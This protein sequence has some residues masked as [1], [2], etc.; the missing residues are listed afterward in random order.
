MLL[1]VAE[2]LL[3]F[4]EFFPD[5]VQKS[6][7]ARMQFRPWRLITAQLQPPFRGG[8]TV[9]GRFREPTHTSSNSRTEIASNC[10]RPSA[11]LRD[12]PP[13]TRQRRRIAENGYSAD[14]DCRVSCI[15]RFTGRTMGSSAAG[16]GGLT[17]S[18]DSL[19]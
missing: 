13:L 9:P 11:V 18:P 19:K 4:E 7:F 5:F 17:Q 12:S 6:E 1:Q 8:L 14:S 2:L 10:A 15:G 3:N 16:H